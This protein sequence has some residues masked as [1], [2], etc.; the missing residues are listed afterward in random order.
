VNAERMMLGAGIA[1]FLITLFWVRN[2][3][4]REKYA[5]LWLLASLCLLLLGF[6]PQ[7]I[8]ELAKVCHL[9]YVALV[10]LVG[11]VLVYTFGFF[12]SVAL[13]RQYRRNVQLAQQLTLTNWRLRKLEEVVGKPNAHEE[14]KGI[15]SRPQETT[16]NGALPDSSQG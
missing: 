7:S 16:E 1:A 8:M 10:L 3:E 2:R 13:T 12:V 6:F 14:K 11:L 5:M 9:S 4:I 15:G